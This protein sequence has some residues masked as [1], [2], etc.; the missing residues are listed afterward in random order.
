MHTYIISYHILTCIDDLLWYFIS[1]LLL[2][3]VI[4]IALGSLCFLPPLSSSFSLHNNIIIFKN[5]KY[6][7]HYLII[8]SN[9]NM[10]HYPFSLVCA[11]IFSQ[12]NFCA[13]MSCRCRSF[14]TCVQTQNIMIFRFGFIYHLTWLHLKISAIC[15]PPNTNVCMPCHACLHI[16]LP[17][18]LIFYE[19]KSKRKKI[20]TN[21]FQQQNNS[22]T[23]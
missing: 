23:C 7:T 13:C 20:L 19:G 21:R 18:L 2:Y 16:G 5:G 1:Y 17:P 10:I 11:S 22:H 9:K 12:F 6:T 4:T 14:R 8:A 3:P 15:T